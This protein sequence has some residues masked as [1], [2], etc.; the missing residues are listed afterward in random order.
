MKEAFISYPIYRQPDFQKRF[1]IH[2]D[3][4]NDAL[5]VVLAQKEDVGAEY[6]CAYASRILRAEK[7]Y[8]IT[9]K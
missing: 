1:I 9:E 4:S 2:T 5:G 3:A 7:H 6:V 8:G